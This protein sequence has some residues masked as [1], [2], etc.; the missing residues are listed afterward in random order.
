MAPTRSS[1][2]EGRRETQTGSAKA[3]QEGPEKWK[4]ADNVQGR[5]RAPLMQL[6]RVRGEVMVI[7]DENAHSG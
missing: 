7:I 6:E 1:F 2:G 5:V 4:E 3:F